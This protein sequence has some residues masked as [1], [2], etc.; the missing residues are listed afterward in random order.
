MRN[1]FKGIFAFLVITAFITPSFAVEDTT[2][3]QLVPEVK[4][5]EILSLDQKE[6]ERKKGFEDQL[7]FTIPTYTDNPSYVITFV[8]PSPEKSGVQLE[9]D[10]EKYVE[11]TSPY[12]FP[13]LSIGQHHLSFKFTDKDGAVQELEYDLSILPRPPIIKTPSFD[14]SVIHLAGTGLANSEVILFLSSNTNSYPQVVEVDGEG[15]WS[16]D[17]EPSSINGIYTVVGY[18]RKYG[19]ASDL[20]QSVVFQVGDS[21]NTNEESDDSKVFFSF[22]SINGDNFQDI[23]TQN[24]DLLILAGGTF[25]LGAIL[26][27]I[28]KSISINGKIEKSVERAEQSIK[29]IGK[30]KEKTLRELFEEQTP[31][32][33]KKP[34]PEKKTE[35]KEV[36]EKKKDEKVISKEEFLKKFKMIDPDDS[37]GKEKK[38]PIV[39]KGVKISLTSHEEE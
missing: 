19:Y 37:K 17:I 13:A 30:P 33:E 5:E 20:S 28:L 24:R 38:G 21:V 26:A 4:A 27:V 22:A 18:T 36:K 2:L 29:S 31:I 12:T 6:I 35:V 7:G 39:N 32:E 10:D 3:S 8:D 16:A 14:D 1:I 11:I 34:V 9:I 15:N 23:F 25:L